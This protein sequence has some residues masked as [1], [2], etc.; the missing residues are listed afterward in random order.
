LAATS[1]GLAFWDGRD[2]RRIA[3]QG[4]AASKRLRFVRRIGA[5]R[6]V[7]GGDEPQLLLYGSQGVEGTVA[8]PR[9]AGGMQCLAGDLED[10]TV[11]VSTRDGDVPCLTTHVTG[12]WLKSLPL[13]R[14]G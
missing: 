10:L 4:L 1:D 14:V 2:W 3:S 7:I 12:R 5:G 6:W 9:D 8:A 13:P 11:L